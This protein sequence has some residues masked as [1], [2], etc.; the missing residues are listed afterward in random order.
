MAAIN[1]FA[2]GSNLH[3]LRL[4]ARV[5]SAKLIGNVELS[6][7]RLTFHKRSLDGSGKCLIFPDQ[8][9]RSPVF[10][11]L[12]EFKREEKQLLD[13]VEGLGSGYDE[14]LLELICGKT[15]YTAYTY[16]AQP[17]YIDTALAP[18]HWYKQLV[19]AGSRYHNFPQSYIENLEATISCDDP[20]E[21][22]TTLNEA[23]LQRINK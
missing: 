2:Y 20:D 5:P 4:A 8:D 18:Y 23:L 11:A 15:R 9:A 7:Y 1:Y 16:I 10:G 14:S 22:R 13:L 21:E 6:G 17:A 3:P 19:V 12:Y